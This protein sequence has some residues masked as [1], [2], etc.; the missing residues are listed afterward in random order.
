MF[1][2]LPA[3]PQQS[4]LFIS[5]KLVGS[6]EAEIKAIIFM[7]P[8]LLGGGVGCSSVFLSRILVAFLSCSSPCSL[9]PSTLDLSFFCPHL[10]LCLK[11]KTPILL[12]EER[13]G[14]CPGLATDRQMTPISLWK[15]P[16]VSGRPEN[17]KSK[18]CLRKWQV[19]VITRM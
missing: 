18:L 7:S 4:F 2:R 9:C 12:T 19:T 17:E 3:R 10:H 11:D 8:T 5:G 1:I 14:F 13:V 15:S 6:Y 16:V